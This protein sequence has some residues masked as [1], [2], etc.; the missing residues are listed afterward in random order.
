MTEQV[1]IV[2]GGIGG[3]GSALLLSRAGHQVT[4]LDRDDLT[5]R[6]DPDAAFEGERRGAP[7]VRHTHGF[8][9]RLTGVLR[10]HFADVLDDLHDAGAYEVGLEGPA[11]DPRANP[12]EPRILI[13]RRTTLEWALRRAVATDGRIECRSGVAAESLAGDP[14]SDGAPA[15]VRGVRLSGEGADAAE[16]LDADTVIAAGGRRQN[17]PALLAPLGVTITEAEED[18]GIIYLTRWYRHREGWVPDGE[19]KL[20]G[21]LG[22]VKYLVI[23]GDA[24]TISA[25][26]AIPSNDREVRAALLDGDRFDRAVAMLPGPDHVM[27]DGVDAPI[28]PVNPMGG[29]VNRIRTFVDAGGAPLVTGLHAVGD[30]HTCTNPFYGRGCSLALVQACLLADAFA[31]HPDDAAARVAAYEAASRRD[32]EPWYHVSGATDS[33]GRA[34]ARRRQGGE[35]D[36]DIAGDGD[37]SGQLALAMRAV[38]LGGATDPVIGQGVWKVMNMLATPDQLFL[39]PE[40]MSRVQALMADPAALGAGFPTGPDR[41]ELLAAVA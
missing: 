21:D 6:P 4:V 23:P 17:V 9:A 12:E 11:E 35:G 31:A 30:A 22:F 1:V 5:A 25:T 32:V 13:A 36:A 29:L 18:T 40:F 24:G 2:G 41:A 10:E 33:F 3:L 15:V 7:Q 27:A 39:D 28:G 38:I 34:A 26:L 19:A 16:V 14:A 20:A 8:L 37:D